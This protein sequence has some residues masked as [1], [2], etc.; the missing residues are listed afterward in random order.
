MLITE[1]ES[2][3]EPDFGEKCM[4]S[5]WATLNLNVTEI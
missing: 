1:K 5:A 3:E 2:L 4:H